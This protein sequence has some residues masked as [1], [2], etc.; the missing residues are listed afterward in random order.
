MFIIFIL[1]A[2]YHLLCQQQLLLH[3]VQLHA[4]DNQSTVLA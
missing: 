2:V 1:S 3:R 4:L